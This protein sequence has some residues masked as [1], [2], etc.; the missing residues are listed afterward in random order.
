MNAM[1]FY[2]L[3]RSGDGRA[4]EDQ[5]DKEEEPADVEHGAPA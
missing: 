5:N 1:Q 2:I 3:V 4:A